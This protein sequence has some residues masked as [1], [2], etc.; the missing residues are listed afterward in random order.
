MLPVVSYEYNLFND[1]RACLGFSNL[2][3]SYVAGGEVR[4]ADS[5]KLHCGTGNGGNPGTPV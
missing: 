1:Q 2:M 3:T 4:S 5:G